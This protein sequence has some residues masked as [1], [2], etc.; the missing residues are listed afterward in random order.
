MKSNAKSTSAQTP[1]AIV[2]D[3]HALI[4]EAEKLVSENAGEE[5]VT[6]LREKLESAQERLSTCYAQARERVIAGAKYTDEAVRS[7]PYESVAIAAGVGLLVGLLVGRN[8]S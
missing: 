5:A 6:T 2:Q 7:H 1:E 8:R 3:L 4:A